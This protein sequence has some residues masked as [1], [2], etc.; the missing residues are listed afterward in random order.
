M[1][2]L[3]KIPCAHL[4]SVDVQIRLIHVARPDRE[5]SFAAVEATAAMFGVIAAPRR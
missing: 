1:S 3:P 2:R 4:E 5:L